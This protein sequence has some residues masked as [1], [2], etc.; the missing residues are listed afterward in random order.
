MTHYSVNETGTSQTYDN[1]ASRYVQ[2]QAYCSTRNAQ[3]SW[4][5]EKN[6]CRNCGTAQPET[7]MQQELRRHIVM[8]H[9]ID[10]WTRQAQDT[11]RCVKDTTQCVGTHIQTCS[12]HKTIRQAAGERR[13]NDK[14]KEL[15]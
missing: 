10:A 3:T 12:K 14:Q 1:R 13:H 9:D 4:L 6:L 5:N 8:T 2:P 15:R 7:H 11:T